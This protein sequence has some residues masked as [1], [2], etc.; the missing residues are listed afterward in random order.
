MTNKAKLKDIIEEMEMQIEGYR[1]FIKIR[2]GEVFL[3][4]EDDLI[5]TEDEKPMIG[6]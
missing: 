1:S 4:S 5:D 6:R 3:I 2:T